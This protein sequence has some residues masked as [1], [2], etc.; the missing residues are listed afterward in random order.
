MPYVNVHIDGQDVLDEMNDDEIRKELF[1]RE[2]KGKQGPPETEDVL[3]E[4]IFQYYRGKDNPYCLREYI[5]R[6]IGRII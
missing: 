5:Y 1:R 6:K 3:L 2:S 4:Q